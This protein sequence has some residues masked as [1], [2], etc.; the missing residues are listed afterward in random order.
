[1]YNETNI[2]TNSITISR[3][4]MMLPGNTGSCASVNVTVIAITDVG[5]TQPSYTLHTGFPICKLLY[6]SLFFPCMCSLLYSQ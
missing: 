1:M 6:S 5:S 3:D 2:S 4:Y